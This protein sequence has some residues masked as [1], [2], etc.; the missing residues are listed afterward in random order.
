MN[1]ETIRKLGSKSPTRRVLENANVSEEVID[2]FVEPL[3]EPDRV[4]FLTSDDEVRL[5]NFA[6]GISSAISMSNICQVMPIVE[7]VP[8]EE[9]PQLEEEDEAENAIVLA[10]NDNPVDR[11]A[12]NQI[13]AALRMVNFPTASMQSI[14]DS[15]GV[16]RQTIYNWKKNDDFIAFLNQSNKSMVEKSINVRAKRNAQVFD[17]VHEELLSRMGRPTTDEAELRRILGPNYTQAQLGAY[18]NRFI[19]NA[20]L[21]D[22]F[23]IWNALEDKTRKDEEMMGQGES[24]ETILAR[25][26]ARYIQY[27]IERKKQSDFEKISGFTY[28]VD[29]NEQNA[30]S[31][32]AENRGE[33]EEGAHEDIVDAE[34]V[35]VVDEPDLLDMFAAE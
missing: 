20:S 14:A 1:D 24:T 10:V 2:T 13:Q 7:E 23:T 32:Y 31:V 9:V 11:L 19:T 18:R 35:E 3:G 21:R 5:S 4:V 22:V 28:D 34:F 8:P 33:L 15:V 29:F 27:Q 30:V 26:Q 16:S 17:G 25:L 12:P 6:A